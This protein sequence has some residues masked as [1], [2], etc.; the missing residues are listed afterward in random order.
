[1]FGIKRKQKKRSRT[2]PTP[3]WGDAS[4]EDSFV[5]ERAFAFVKYTIDFLKAQK[6]ASLFSLGA[7]RRGGKLDNALGD[8]CPPLTGPRQFR[9]SLPSHAPR[10]LCFP[11]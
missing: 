10:R 6:G 5:F 7:V 1:M 2:G 3:F 8:R 11:L 4:L 9:P